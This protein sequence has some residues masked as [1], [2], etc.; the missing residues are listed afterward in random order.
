[1]CRKVKFTVMYVSRA[2]RNFVYMNRQENLHSVQSLGYLHGRTSKKSEIHADEMPRLNQ[3]QRMRAM[4]MVDAGLRHHDVANR[5]GVTRVTIARLVRR[6]RTRGSADDL[7]RSGRPRVTTPEQDRHIR[8][9]HLR[10]RFLPATRTAAV[11]PGRTNNRISAQTVRNRL[12]ER[13]L[14]PYR[15]YTGPMLTRRHRQVRTDWTR[16]HARWT[17]LQWYSVLFTDEPRFC[18][19]R[20]DGRERVYRRRGERYADA[21]VR[22]VDRYGGG[23]V[24]VWGGI[25]FQN[26]TELVIVDGNLN[27]QRYCDEILAPVVVPFFN[28]NRRISLLQQDNA[29]CHTARITTDFLAEEHI[30]VLP[31][32]ALSPD[33]SPIEHL[34]DALD[35]RVRL[36]QP[37]T[38]RQLT[39]ILREEWN[40]I[41]QVEIQT[42][43][44]SMRRRCIAT[45]DAN[46]GHTR[47]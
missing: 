5:L 17:Q 30:E 36:R 24:M 37:A 42:L 16:Q 43:I 23:S 29:R 22:Q 10:D 8:T 21:C 11:T 9:S 2:K 13:G 25:T 40:N 26:R 4:G 46:G 3:N 34:W 27:S 39:A 14:R 20:G 31:W 38:L 41:D 33:L 12:S 45:R 6:Y 7:P 32:P 18:L 44:R 28:A 15:P 47:Y 1:M 19:R 35:R